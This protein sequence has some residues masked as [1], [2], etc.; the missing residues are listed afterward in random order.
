MCRPVAH[1]YNRRMMSEAPLDPWPNLCAKIARL[2]E[3]R[4]WNQEEFARN[5]G[6]NRLT[7]RSIVLGPERRLHNATVAACAR[8]L[9]LSVSDLRHLPLD[10]L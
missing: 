1:V 3:E 7:I 5:A 9:G 8:A 2:A 4:G 10:R 6:L